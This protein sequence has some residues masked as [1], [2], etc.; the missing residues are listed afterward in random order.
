MDK[1]YGLPLGKKRFAH[2]DE[3]ATYLNLV[4]AGLACETMLR[5]PYQTKRADRNDA[6]NASINNFY[7]CAFTQLFEPWLKLLFK[8]P[9]KD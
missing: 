5:W 7:I 2:S 8:L 1:K 9:V 3:Q 6:L 4:T